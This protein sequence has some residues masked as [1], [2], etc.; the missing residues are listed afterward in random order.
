M[1]K[2]EYSKKKRKNERRESGKKIQN[3]LNDND[4]CIYYMADTIIYKLSS[5]I[6][7]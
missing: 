3:Q 1:N 4:E 7:T 5:H 6:Q 2:I